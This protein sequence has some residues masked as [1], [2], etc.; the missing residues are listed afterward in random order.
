MSASDGAPGGGGDD[1]DLFAAADDDDVAGLEELETFGTVSGPQA[2]A[3]GLKV[4]L[5]QV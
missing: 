5:P 4:L 3:G 1:D 2:A